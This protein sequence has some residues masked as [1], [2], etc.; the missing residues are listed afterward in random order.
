MNFNV[1]FRLLT[2]IQVIAETLIELEVRVHAGEENGAA[3]VHTHMRTG[4]PVEEDA[5]YAE[6][7]IHCNTR[8]A[9]SFCINEKHE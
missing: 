4:A 2:G 7:I 8:S 5:N 1:C 6:Y 9:T 3:L